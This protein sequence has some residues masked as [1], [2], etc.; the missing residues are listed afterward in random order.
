MN[1]RINILNNKEI[2]LNL[3][4]KK[5]SINDDKFIYRSNSETRYLTDLDSSKIYDVSIQTNINSSF[6]TEINSNN[7]QFK[8]GYPTK[9]EKNLIYTIDGVE[10]KISDGIPFK[11]RQEGQFLVF[12]CFSK[13]N[14]RVG[15]FILLSNSTYEVFDLGVDPLN[16]Y[17]V[18]RVLFDPFID[19]STYGSFKKIQNPND[20]TTVSEYYIEIINL[21]DYNI[22]S[23][24]LDFSKTLL[25]TNRL[26]LSGPTSVFS[27]KNLLLTLNNF[28]I[29]NLVDEN[30]IPI[31]QLSIIGLLNG[32]TNQIIWDFNRF[33]DMSLT[34][35]DYIRPR[36]IFN[37]LDDLDVIY[38]NFIEFSPL[39]FTKNILSLPFNKIIGVNPSET[40]F[41]Y[42]NT[43]NINLFSFD[44]E[45]KT[46]LYREDAPDYAIYN[47]SIGLWFWREP[48][49]YSSNTEDIIKFSF[50]NKKHIINNVWNIY[51]ENEVNN[52]VINNPIFNQIVNV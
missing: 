8:I 41:G 19:R 32:Y 22:I 10:F 14:L 5:S 12:D 1:K 43:F 13:H 24:T 16:S 30:N 20:L 34:N 3:E 50:I 48:I 44:T 42:Y 7:F 23:N 47:E 45:L 4:N 33:N 15:D 31:S 27:N 49:A 2:L 25:T 35:A 29:N 28:N 39:N 17:R 40:F 21:L 36:I 38:G 11:C 18:F 9:K 6:F 37:N 46:S 51:L 52:F 26:D